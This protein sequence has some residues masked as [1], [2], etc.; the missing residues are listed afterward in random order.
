MVFTNNLTTNINFS[1]GLNESVEGDDFDYSQI[2]E[3]SLEEL[4]V[5]NDSNPSPLSPELIRSLLLENGIITNSQVTM[6]LTNVLVNSEN[7]SKTIKTED[8]NF[9]QLEDY[10][11]KSGVTQETKYYRGSEYFTITPGLAQ[12]I[13]YNPYTDTFDEN[14][15]KK[16]SLGNKYNG[17][18]WRFRERGYLYIE[19][20][21][22]YNRFLSGEYISQPYQI[23]EQSIL[24]FKVACYIW[25]GVKE[26]NTKK[27]SNDFA[28]EKG[29]ASTFEQTIKLSCPN[30]KERDTFFDKFVQ[31]LTKFKDKNGES[32]ISYERP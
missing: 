16:D 5:T 27:S 9:P 6:F 13:V 2:T 18:S 19:G 21:D 14:E 8:N 12:N 26:L 15:N 29:D 1:V 7:L 32:L 31:V 28:K 23:S 3:T 22:D 25:T 10:I 20:R 30:L 24:S 11:V 17:D 4:G